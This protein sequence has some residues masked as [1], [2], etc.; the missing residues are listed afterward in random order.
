MI[1]VDLGGARAWFTDRHGGTS[2]A[3]FDSMNLAAHVGDDPAA[4]ARNR[5]RLAAGVPGVPDD[6]ARWVWLRQ[7]HG[8]DVLDARGPS[9]GVQADAA[10]STVADLP[11]VVLT[12]DCAPIA[13]VCGDAVG[14][15]HA[16]WP[17]LEQR[18][19]DAAVARVRCLGHGDVRAAIGP[20]VHPADY[21]FGADHLERLVDVLGPE[22]A[23]RTATGAPAFDVPAAV[24][25][26][27]ERAGVTEIH[28]VD[29]S[30][31]ASP[32]HFSYRRDGA[33][34]RQAVVVM[35][36]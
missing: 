34:G 18:V 28:D 30:S 21:E 15:V 24:R 33:T 7:V 17:G 22:V 10:V 11:L 9:E 2:E 19:I 20:C 1:E 5:A 3:P 36:T 35:R 25:S 29:V 16:G 32:D 8:A 4:V 14:V 12:A 23:A 13:L 27:L 6:P 26:A 31:A